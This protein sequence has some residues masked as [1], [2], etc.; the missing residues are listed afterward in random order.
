[1][2]G[3]TNTTTM[4][5]TLSDLQR[6]AAISP[7]GRMRWTLTRTWDARPT[8]VACMFNP[9]T[10]D[11]LEDD[12][13][14][15]LLSHIASHNGYGTLV[16]VNGVPIRSP[17]PAPAYAMLS[18]NAA[19]EPAAVAAMRENLDHILAKTET[20][21]AFLLAWGALAEKTQASKNWFDELVTHVALSLPPGGQVFCLGRTASGAP[22]HPLARG[23]L[24]LSKTAL[25]LPF[26][27]AS[28][29]A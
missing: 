11:A 6:G 14:I 13:T 23:K 4:D 7:C 17:D 21:G 5:F 28:I 25:L 1:M 27:M 15:S 18:D 9:S 19:G 12:P 29:R 2:N 22:L 10:A 16:V 24:K 3:Q 20:A 26:N 8:L